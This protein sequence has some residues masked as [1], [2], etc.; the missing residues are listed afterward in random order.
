MRTVEEF[1]GAFATMTKERV[2]AIFVVASSLTGRGR[3]APMLL[4]ELAMKHRLPSMFGYKASGRRR[5]HELLA[6][7]HR[8]HSARR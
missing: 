8:A 1:E 3:D 5:S 6:K 2:D 4:A 7:L